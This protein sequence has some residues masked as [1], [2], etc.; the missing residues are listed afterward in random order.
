[1]AERSSAH[2][3]CAR[4]PCAY[5]DFCTWHHGLHACMPVYAARC[6]LCPPSC[7]RRQQV[8]TGAVHGVGGV[9]LHRTCAWAAFVRV[10]LRLLPR[11]RIA[12]IPVPSPRQ[13]CGQWRAHRSRHSTHARWQGFRAQAER[14]GRSRPQS[15]TPWRRVPRVQEASVVQ[16]QFVSFQARLAGT[17]GAASAGQLGVSHGDREMGGCG[18]R[19][20]HGTQSAGRQA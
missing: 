10:L 13:Q 8:C 20:P 18:L 17:D 2:A 5:R 12:D 7:L 3:R 11:G 6:T 15:G 14:R 9:G 1:M 16:Y 4:G 19:R